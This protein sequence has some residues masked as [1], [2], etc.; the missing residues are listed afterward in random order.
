MGEGH[1]RGEDEYGVTELT[2]YACHGTGYVWKK[3]T[4]ERMKKIAEIIRENP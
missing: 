1:W 2:C 4:V 3:P